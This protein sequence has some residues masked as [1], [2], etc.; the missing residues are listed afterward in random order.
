MHQIATK[1]N[2]LRLGNNTIDDDGLEALVDSMADTRLDKLHLDCEQAVTIRGWQTFS[3]LLEAQSSTL[4]E[5]SLAR[6]SID[7]QSIEALMPAPDAFKTLRRVSFYENRFMSIHGW[8]ALSQLL[9]KPNSAL[10]ELCLSHTNLDDEKAVLLADS[11]VGNKALKVLDLWGSGVTSTRWAA[12]SKLICDKSSVNKTY[13]SNHTLSEI[14]YGSPYH[15]TAEIALLLNLNRNPDKTQV[16]IMKILQNH[17]H[18]DMKPLF[19]W[20]FK[21]LPF[22]V[23]WFD[24]AA[25]YISLSEELDIDVQSKKLSAIYHFIRGLPTVYIESRLKQQLKV[26]RERMQRM[27]QKLEEMQQQENA[28]IAALRSRQLSDAA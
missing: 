25:D 23:D 13:L 22:V 28:L 17:A 24:R 26:V 6:N 18:L 4:E 16:A 21:T 15:P 20:E 5:L 10:E 3:A 2:H 14:R 12:F 19:E 27:R 9:T 11:L 7:D 1:L 8:R